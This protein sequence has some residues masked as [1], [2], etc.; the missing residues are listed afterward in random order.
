MLSACAGGLDLRKVE[1][2]RSI[3]TSSVSHGSAEVADPMEA[4]DEATIRNAV[5]SIDL[6]E[7]GGAEIPWANPRTGSRGSISRIGDYRQEGAICRRFTASRESFEGVRL[8]NG[9][10]CLG[11]SGLWRTLSFK[12][13]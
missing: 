5:S 4:S 12:A 8:Y 1:A 13:A 7:L 3:I 9:D 2:D 10:V 6:E 11:A